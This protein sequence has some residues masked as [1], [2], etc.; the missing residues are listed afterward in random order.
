MRCHTESRKEQGR[1]K[2]SPVGVDASVHGCSCMKQLKDVLILTPLEADLIVQHLRA[3]EP[4]FDS[5]CEPA[6]Y[7]TRWANGQITAKTP[8]TVCMTCKQPTASCTAAI[9]KLCLLW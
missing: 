8:A 1:P 5:A 4:W 9:Q 3:A 7:G 6:C 2:Q